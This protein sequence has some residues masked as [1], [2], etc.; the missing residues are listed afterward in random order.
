[1]DHADL[2]GLNLHHKRLDRI[3]FPLPPKSKRDRVL[4][5]FQC[6]ESESMSHRV[7]GPA[8][9]RFFIITPQKPYAFGE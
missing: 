4:S 6:L 8:V 2:V 7:T 5:R 9:R 3:A 1:M